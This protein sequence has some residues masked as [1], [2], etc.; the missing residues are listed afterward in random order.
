MQTKQVLE[1]IRR[2]E[3]RFSPIY[4]RLIKLQ[5]IAYGAPPQRSSDMGRVVIEISYMFGDFMETVQQDHDSV[6]VLSAFML[7][8]SLLK[9][10]FWIDLASE[11]T[12]GERE[13]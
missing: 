6:S 5:E 12:S 8:E 10:A 3:V 9:R 11:L 7:G 2:I 13:G 4:E 1:T